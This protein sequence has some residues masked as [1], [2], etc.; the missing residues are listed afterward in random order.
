MS[1]EASR[2]KRE[3]AAK[4]AEEFDARAKEIRQYYQNFFGAQVK[5]ALQAVATQRPEKPTAVIAD[6]FLGKKSVGEIASE[7]RTKS[8]SLREMAPRSYLHASVGEALSQDLARCFREQ[9]RR[10]ISELGAM[11][12]KHEA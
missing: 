10:P 8:Q 3:E 7:P 12:A 6:V 11:L 2:L 1:D 4:A 5:E 9:P